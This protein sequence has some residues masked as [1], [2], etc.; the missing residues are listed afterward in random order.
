MA[1]TYDEDIIFAY[2]TPV[3]GQ[4]DIYA[5]IRATAK[6]FA[7]ALRAQVPPGRELDQARY[8]LEMVVQ[9][10]NAGIAREPARQLAELS[11]AVK[12]ASTPIRRPGVDAVEKAGWSPPLS[13]HLPGV[14]PETYGPAE[15][16][17]NPRPGPPQEVGEDQLPDPGTPEYPPGA[18]H[19]TITQESPGIQVPRPG[20]SR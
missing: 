13:I 16:A 15:R 17:L 20:S 18:T 12:T 7:L 5:Q 3:P 8:H 11:D 6:A 2:H 14:D 9:S 19:Q 10:A 4:S 1:D